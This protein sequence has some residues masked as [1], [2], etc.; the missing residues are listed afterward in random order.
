MELKT[1]VDAF[2]KQI[3][4]GDLL[5]A[6]ETYYSEDVTMQENGNTATIGK[7]ANRTRELAFVDM[8]ADV[9]ENRA[10][11]VIA[12]GDKVAINWIMDLTLKN[13]ARVK[14]DQIALQT[15]KDGKIVSERFYYD[16]GAKA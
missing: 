4:S 15:W 10:A 8:V 3:E 5:G 2:V 11:S 1:T 16:T 12:G 14:Y 9:H 6:F 7:D 13:G